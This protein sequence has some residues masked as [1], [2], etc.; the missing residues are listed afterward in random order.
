MQADERPSLAF[1][2]LQK[3]L[4]DLVSPHLVQVFSERDVIV[5]D[6]DFALFLLAALRC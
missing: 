3:C 2:R 5:G 4:T 1:A 6:A